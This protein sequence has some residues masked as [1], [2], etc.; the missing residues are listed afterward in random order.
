MGHSVLGC[1]LSGLGTV[2]I[3]PRDNSECGK[4]IVDLNLVEYMEAR[5]KQKMLVSLI[6]FTN[7]E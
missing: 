6:E 4:G 7:E 2:K 1:L 3:S 5:Q